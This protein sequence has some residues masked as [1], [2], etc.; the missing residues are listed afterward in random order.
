MIGDT[1]YDAQSA[2]EAYALALQ[3]AIE[4]PA[5]PGAS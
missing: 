1:M 2:V 4:K 3:A 5:A